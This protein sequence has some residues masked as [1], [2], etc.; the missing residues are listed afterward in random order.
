MTAYAVLRDLEGR[1]ISIAKDGDDLVLTP[2]VLVDDALLTVIREAKPR[3]LALLTEQEELLTLLRKGSA[4]MIEMNM[5]LAEASAF[6]DGQTDRLG[7]AKAHF[8]VLE[9]ALR[10]KGYAGC[11]D[12]SGS[13]PDDAVVRC[14]ACVQE[15]ARSASVEP[16]EVSA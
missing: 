5:Q 2:R 1:G 14:Q 4:W 7:H 15:S 3:L 9:R 16:A 11:V 10:S 8:E 13:C 12:P 6:V